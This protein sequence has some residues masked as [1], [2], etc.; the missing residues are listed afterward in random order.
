MAE[1]TST[2]APDTISLYQNIMNAFYF[3]VPNQVFSG[4]KK[5]LVF[6]KYN[7]E[8][9]THIYITDPY[10]K[11]TLHVNKRSKEHEDIVKRRIEYYAAGPNDTFDEL[12]RKFLEFHS[13][14]KKFDSIIR[15]NLDPELEGDVITSGVYGYLNLYSD[16]LK[17]ISVYDNIEGI[18]VD[19]V[20][21]AFF[22]PE[23]DWIDPIIRRFI[24]KRKVLHRAKE[25]QIKNNRSIFD[26]LY[27]VKGGSWMDEPHFICSGAKEIYPDY[28]AIIYEDR[29]YTWAD[30]YKRT[31]KFASALNK[32]GIK[33]G[34][35]VSFLAFNTPE[36]FEGHYSVPMSGAVLNTINIRLDAK[37]IAYILEHSDAKVLVVDR[38][39]HIEVKKALSTLKKKITIIDIVDKFADQSKCEKIGDLEYESF[40]N[41]GDEN[42]DWKM[43]DDEWQAISLSYTSGTTG[44]PKG[45]V[46][47]HRGSYLMSTGLSLIHI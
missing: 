40:L 5:G 15:T 18:Y 4:E 25:N 46:Y 16:T 29:K 3:P 28:E 26:S 44:N 41:T 47:H 22:D 7:S 10:T 2:I 30:V 37:T 33:K 43:P 24:H 19:L 27:V 8:D 17:R 36:I 1:W 34:D 11:Q 42:F 20:A 21:N 35:T 39:L 45:V 31:I 38:Q 12:K 13:I 23:T 14:D 6:P 32:I 9:N